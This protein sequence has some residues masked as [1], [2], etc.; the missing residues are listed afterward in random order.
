MAAAE[1]QQLRD[2]HL[3]QTPGLW[4]PAPGWWL[5]AL[6][7]AAA[8]LWLV[9]RARAQYRRRRPLRFARRLYA[10]LHQRLER[11]E[12]T[13]REYLDATNELLKRVLIHGLGEHRARRA[14][15]TAW[16]AL[17]DQ[18]LG[19]TEFSA[20]PGQALG[21]RRFEP[22]PQADL[23]QLHPLVERLL[24]EL[25]PPPAPAATIRLRGRVTRT[26]LGRAPGGHS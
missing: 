22:E 11:G 23:A 8:V 4:P 15:G 9:W 25:S 5:L 2:I 17:L 14:S 18:H 16:L 10:D 1:L 7:A 21:N 12:L 20:G 26:L 19:S 6:L 13:T 3:P 24:A